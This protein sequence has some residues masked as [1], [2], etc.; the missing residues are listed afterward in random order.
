MAIAAAPPN[1]HLLLEVRCSPSSTANPISHYTEEATT[2]SP[3]TSGSL[4]LDGY[5]P[6]WT[7]YA[8]VAVSLML[9]FQ[10]GWSI[11]QLNLAAFANQ[12]ACD[13]RPVRDGTCLMFPGH[14]K[15]AWTYV[16][17]AWVVGGMI[18][19]LSCG[20]LADV[21]GRRRALM[22]SAV[23]MIVGG[24]IQASASGIPA[25]VVGRFLAGI[26]SGSATGMVGGYVNEI[27][28]PHL[29]GTLSGG[30]Q[31]TLSLGSF[32]VVC[33]FF[34]ANTSSGWRYIAGFQV[35]YGVLFLA[36]ASFLLAE[37]PAWLLTKGK[38]DA[39]EQVAARIYGEQY[40]SLAL[41]WLEEDRATVAA[42]SVLEGIE[43]PTPRASYG[44]RSRSEPLLHTS[45]PEP[46]AAQNNT[47]PLLLSPLFRRQVMVAI[48]ISI[49]QQL[50]GINAVS[51]YSSGIF[52][53]AGISDD[54]VGNLVSTLMGFVPTFAVGVV[55][56]RFGY[57][58]VL[59][60]GFLGMLVCA[61]GITVALLT[62]STALSIIF[63]G[64]YVG[65]FSLSLGPLIYAVV[66][67]LFP[68]SIRATASAVCIFFS[69]LSNLIVGV[70][71]PYL[72]AA[73]GDLSFLPF[74]ATLSIFFVLT[75]K[76]LPETLGRTSDEIQAE[77]RTLRQEKINAG[78]R[79]KASAPGRAE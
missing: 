14:S 20:T 50:S 44:T 41:S 35:I 55:A 52:V 58:R 15:S 54:R 76:T 22:A 30:L 65:C 24:A 69:W 77:F 68:A 49:A 56:K 79:D 2:K 12:D 64:A 59:L 39:A 34:V 25:F 6:S 18:G 57:R 73:L 67:D 16:V 46:L 10:F 60:A 33:V 61:V 31:I 7:L 75:V 27:A 11:S 72:T 74:V 37:S 53:D 21:Y 45:N 51:Y 17:N 5:K 70:S 62:G 28:P 47:V 48:M 78:V 66:A 26:S 63:I 42:A 36:L 3:A 4:A 43:I 23:F 19:S 40:V 71:F 32:L 29:R 8:S 38:R 9:P 13:A 1:D